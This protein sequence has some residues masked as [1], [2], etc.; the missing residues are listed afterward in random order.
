MTAP[1]NT[2][3]LPAGVPIDD[4]AD[5]EWEAGLE[6]PAV[7]RDREAAEAKAAGEP[8]PRPK[9]TRARW[10]ATL[11]AAWRQLTSMRTALLLLLLLAVAAVPGSIFPQ[12]PVN[13]LR[14]Q[15]YLS[16]HPKWGP[17]L[18]RLSGFDVFT[19]PWF[20]AIY[21]LLMVSLIGCV[22]PRLR[23]HV[24]TL[25]AP[26]PKAPAHPSRLPSGAS[27]T[28][29][30]APEEAVA[31]ARAVLR[32]ARFRAV[33][34]DRSNGFT[35]ASEKGLLR[36]TGNLLFHFS[37][38]A[39]LVGVAVGSLFGYSG[40]VL[41]P[42]GKTFTNTLVA[43][44][45][46]TP[47]ARV[48]RSKLQP[49]SLAL[50]DF[51]ATYRATGEPAA[52]A[53]AVQ[54]RTGLDGPPRSEVLRVNHPLTL[55]QT[56][57]YLTGHG[58]AP[59]FVLRDRTGQVLFDDYVPCTPRGGTEPARSSCTVKIPD[60][61]LPPAGPLRVPQQLA[62]RSS[63]IAD[64]AGGTA[65]LRSPVMQLSSFVGD[66]HLDEGIPQNVYS[67]DPSGLD[68]VRTTG[69]GG[70]DQLVQTVAVGPGPGGVVSGLP[71]GMTLSVDGVRDWSVFAVKHDP[72]KRLV[73]A[74]AV[75]LLIGLV[76]TLTIRRRRV[77]VR[78][79]ALPRNAADEGPGRTLIE[80]GGVTRAG[81]ISV[82][83]DELVGRLQ[84]S[85]TPVD[86]TSQGAEERE[87]RVESQ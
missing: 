39:V 13:P 9:R 74:A 73:L 54:L 61:G 7:R 66:L 21:V 42:E 49:F 19:A 15:Q 62:F 63:L 2:S 34:G 87:T 86:I 36:E 81:D 71:N 29:D 33:L 65:E 20:S 56:K 57:V 77:W 78:A 46:F 45:A 22:V 83:F 52:F 80:V 12:R 67:L 16:D 43:Y 70:A 14:V 38:I 48:D 26:P 55:G 82:E 10:V 30:L 4:P 59:H 85:V 18:D 69:A 50:D 17:F 6:A 24:K 60:V 64:F 72:G 76:L 5:A 23:M 27:W 41:V 53:A 3:G 44:D 79:T 35:V 11:A 8:K 31:R 68:P 32:K 25:L 1:P 84:E 47:G 37:L 58:F 28:T 40:S 75:L 51:T